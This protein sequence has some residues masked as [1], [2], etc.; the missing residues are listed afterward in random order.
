MVRWGFRTYV[1]CH[2]ST[3]GVFLAKAA[4]R[5]VFILDIYTLFYICFATSSIEEGRAGASLTVGRVTSRVAVVA[6]ADRA[7]PSCP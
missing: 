6:R 5:T 1:N 4:R 3:V 2:G 7:Q